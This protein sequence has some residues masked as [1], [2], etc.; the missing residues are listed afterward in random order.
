MKNYQPDKAQLYLYG[1][2]PDEKNLKQFVNRNKLTDRVHFMGWVESELI[3]KNIDLLLMPSLHEGAPNSVLEALKQNICI[4][5]SNIPEHI[6]IL[7]QKYLLSPYLKFEW[8]Y[9]L[10]KIINDPDSMLKNI[11]TAQFIYSQQLYFDWDMKICK[12]I[13]K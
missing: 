12:H 6:E 5:A 7:P 3:W 4:L 2:G 10:Q 8:I 1:V 9:Y 11:C 13:L